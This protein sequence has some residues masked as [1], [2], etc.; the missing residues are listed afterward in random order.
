MLNYKNNFI[1]KVL[2]KFIIQIILFKSIFNYSIYPNHFIFKFLIYYLF[3]IH[4]K[5]IY[6][7]YK[8]S[9]LNLSFIIIIIISIIY[10]I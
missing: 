10:N 1:I 2:Y 5:N 3:Y 4:L 9:Y 7:L 8:K 6:L